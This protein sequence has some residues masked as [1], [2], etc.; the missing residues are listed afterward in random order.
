MAA[1]FSLYEEGGL[2]DGVGALAHTDLAGLVNG[3]N[4]VDL[5]KFIFAI[6]ENVQAG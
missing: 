3:V 6:T 2:Q 5:F 1:D 4:D